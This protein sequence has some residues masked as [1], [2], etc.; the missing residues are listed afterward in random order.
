MRDDVS[1]A[2]V[3]SYSSDEEDSEVGPPDIVRDPWLAPEP[4]APTPPPLLEPAPLAP[5]A[6]PW[7]VPEPFAPA[8]GWAPV[9]GE[10]FLYQG[11]L[12]HWA[13]VYRF[14][15]QIVLLWSESDRL[16][17]AG[18]TRAPPPAITGLQVRWHVASNGSNSKWV[19]YE[20]VHEV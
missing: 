18:N 6:P 9:M 4:F 17:K 16:C 5:L 14:W 8:P 15:D 7:L 12:A 10:S 20:D 19:L 3:E 13:Q 1:A 2:S 11:R